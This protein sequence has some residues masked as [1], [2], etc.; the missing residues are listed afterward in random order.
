MAKMEIEL[1]DEQM[2]KVEIL[3]SKNIDVGQAIDL[4][5]EVQHQ[6]IA[7]V[8]EQPYDEKLLEKIS[9]AGFDSDIKQVLLKMNFDDD[10][11]YDKTVQIAKHNLKWSKFFKF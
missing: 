2:E 8:E 1:T 9:D 11:T 6:I 5:F 10:E 4:L 7:Q 3:K